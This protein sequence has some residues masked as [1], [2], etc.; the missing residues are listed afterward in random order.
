MKNYDTWSGGTRTS[1]G[2]R[3]APSTT[4]ASSAE[5]SNQSKRSKR[6]PTVEP[7]QKA[8]ESVAEEESLLVPTHSTI[9]GDHG[10]VDCWTR[11]V[12]A[13]NPL[14]ETLQPLLSSAHEFAIGRVR[15][16]NPFLLAHGRFLTDIER[17]FCSRDS[18]S[19]SLIAASDVAS[20]LIAA[21]KNGRRAL[22]EALQNKRAERDPAAE[23]L[24]GA[25]TCGPV[26]S[27]SDAPPEVAT[28]NENS[29]L[30]CV[31]VASGADGQGTENASSHC[32]MCS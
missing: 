32:M 9:Q 27:P 4:P 14:R 23:R 28:T 8:P 25:L 22:L 6:A 15:D 10:V 11:I 16:P 13:G 7:P 1:R 19:S 30:I 26:A 29:A 18:P 24:K 2:K 17:A 21:F 5:N 20:V 31:P 12:P 3:K